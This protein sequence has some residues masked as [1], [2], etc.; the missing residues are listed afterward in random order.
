MRC[1][2]QRKMI[3][4]VGKSN[5]WAYGECVF[6]RRRVSTESSL[7]QLLEVPA[8]K[9]SNIFGSSHSLCAR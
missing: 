5:H 6:R 1:A 4:Y 9:A 2:I 3:A 7:F 8:W